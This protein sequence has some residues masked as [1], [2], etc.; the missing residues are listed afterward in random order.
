MYSKNRLYHFGHLRKVLVQCKKFNIS[1][2][3]SK[4]IFGVTKGKI[5]GHIVSV[6]RIIIDLE[7]IVFILNL[8]SPTSK[9]AVKSFMGI[10]NFLCIFFPEITLMVK[11]IHNIL[12]RDHSFYWAEDVENYFTR[13]KKA[14][15][16]APVLVKPNFDKD[17][18]VYTN[19][20]KEEIFVIFLQC[21]EQNNKKLVAYMRQNLSYD[22]F[23]YSYIEKHAFSL[24]KSMKKFCYFIL[25]KHTWVKVPFPTVKFLLLQTYL[26]GKL[27]HC[28]AKI[29]EH[30]LTNMNL[31]TIKGR[32]ISLHLAQH[33]EASEEIDDHDNPLSTLFYIEIQT[34][35]IAK[36]PW[37]K[38]LVYCTCNIK[39]AQMT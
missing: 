7:R 36:H 32:D 17:F 20:T 39:S 25:G 22:E 16:F 12:K 35:S 6:S 5:L 38:N 15:Y 23:K 4:S 10:I 24:F 28:L 19:A 8:A 27:S 33:V 29:Q 37:Y 31:K 14:I 18:I 13:I 2:N 1:L 21:D 3:P 26:S 30:Y 11:L 9:N 34:L